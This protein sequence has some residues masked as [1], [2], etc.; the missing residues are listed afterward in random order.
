MRREEAEESI[1]CANACAKSY[2]DAAH[3]PI[4]LEEGQGA[5]LKLQHGYTIPGLANRKLSQQRVGPFKVLKKK[6]N[7]AYHLELPPIMKIFPVISIAQLEP[8]PVDADP[9]QRERNMPEVPVEY[10]DNLEVDEYHIERILDKRVA[11][12]IY[13]CKRYQKRILHGALDTE[14]RLRNRRKLKSNKGR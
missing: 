8:V 1:A 7:L 2:Y 6:G 5:F 4:T 14:C 11:R 13:A 9:Y 3:T 10:I 12:H